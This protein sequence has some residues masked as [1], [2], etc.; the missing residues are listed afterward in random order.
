MRVSNG[1]LYTAIE[2]ELG[3]GTVALR[4]QASGLLCEFKAFYVMRSTREDTVSE[5][6]CA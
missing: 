2:N 5:M 3:L 4:R 6:V 1:S